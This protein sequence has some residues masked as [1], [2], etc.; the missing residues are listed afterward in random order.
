MTVQRGHSTIFK[1]PT[2]KE[3]PVWVSN[4]QGGGGCCCYTNVVWGRLNLQ[5]R[6]YSNFACH[7]KLMNFNATPLICRL[8]K[9]H[10]NL[11][12]TLSM[13]WDP[14]H[15]VWHGCGQWVRRN[16]SK[17]K[18]CKKQD[19]SGCHQI[20]SY[21]FCVDVIRPGLLSYISSLD[22]IGPCM[23]E[24]Q[25]LVFWW[26]VIKLW[27][28]ATVTPCDEKSIFELLF[29]SIS[30]SSWSDECPGTSTSK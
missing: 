29:I 27:R 15:T 11:M 30:I 12:P 4:R 19:I 8:M 6:I 14:F 7:G 5:H 28:H 17:C 25:N 13:S 2:I 22:S 26:R 10:S 24:I 1:K 9:S 16:T 18:T 23:S 21:D 3:P 20:L